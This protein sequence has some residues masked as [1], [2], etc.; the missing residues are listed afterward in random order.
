MSVRISLH[1]RSCAAVSAKGQRRA[2]AA[3]EAPGRIHGEAAAAA[4]ALAADGEPE[5][6]QEEIVED[7]PP[8]RRRLV[9]FASRENAR[10][11]WPGAAAPAP[12]PRARV[13]QRIV[14]TVGPAV[15]QALHQPPERPLGQPFGQRIDGHE[16]ARVERLV[17]AVLDDLVV[18]HEHLQRPAAVAAGPCRGR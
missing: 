1:T 11:R 15:D 4:L 12:S 9:R 17:F 2:Q 18:L 6:E 3:H 7:E 13:G 10:R 14:E 8:P 16:A 5:L